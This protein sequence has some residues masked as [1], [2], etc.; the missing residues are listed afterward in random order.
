MKLSLLPPI[1]KQTSFK[2]LSFLA[3]SLAT[4]LPLHSYADILLEEYFASGTLPAGWSTNA[5]GTSANPGP[6]LFNN[7]PAMNS[8]SGTY[9]AYFNDQNLNS[10]N[11][12]NVSYLETA[13]V[14]FTGCT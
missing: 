1:L 7:V 5:T 8:T 14:D 6:W 10:V 4:F 9:Y 3:L 11:I 13:P 2:L 12:G